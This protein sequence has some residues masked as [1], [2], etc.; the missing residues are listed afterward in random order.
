VEQEKR[1]GILF[2]S[3]V[4]VHS[5]IKVFIVSKLV[6]D[7]DDVFFVSN[8]VRD[9]DEALIISSRRVFFA[10]KRKVLLLFS[11]VSISDT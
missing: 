2:I 4:A 6:R 10:V 8:V 11:S 5:L 1:S 9:C 7:C 3:I